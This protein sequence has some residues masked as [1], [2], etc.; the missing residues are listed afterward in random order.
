MTPRTKYLK[1]NEFTYDFNSLPVG[2]FK[3]R[4][5]I[6]EH[7]GE[8]QSEDTAYI[9]IQDDKTAEFLTLESSAVL[10]NGGIKND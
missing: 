8:K 3:V 4:A 1:N 9:R 7:S 2:L 6:R 5:F 10:S